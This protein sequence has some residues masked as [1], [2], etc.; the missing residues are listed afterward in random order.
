MTGQTTQGRSLNHAEHGESENPGAQTVR[1][2]QFSLR[3]LLAWGGR[4]GLAESANWEMLALSVFSV[5]SVVQS[6]PSG[7]EVG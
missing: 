7:V 6:L 5:F 1:A 3:R 4:I 2:M